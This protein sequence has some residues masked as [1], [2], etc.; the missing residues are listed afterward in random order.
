M[1]SW[2]VSFGL[3]NCIQCGS[4]GFRPSLLCIH[5]ENNLEKAASDGICIFSEVRGV[6]C[7]G[8]YRWRRDRNRILNRLAVALKGTKQA[9]AWK[10]YAERFLGEWVL[11][12]VISRDAVFVPC[13]AKNGGQDHAYLFARALSRLTGLPLAP[14]L[15]LIDVTEQKR[16][17]K[18]ERQQRAESR[19]RINKLI[20]EKFSLNKVRTIYFVDD[21]ITSGSTLHAAHTQLKKLGHVKAISLI[22]RE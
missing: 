12:E 16:L 17:T 9:D 8:L 22:I 6:Q 4:F 2:P 10:Y 1:L 19:F 21:I 3:N 20:Y 5:C 13:P 14:L 15:E 11:S 7:L 18:L